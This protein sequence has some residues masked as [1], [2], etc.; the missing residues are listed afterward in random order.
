MIEINHSFSKGMSAI[1]AVLFPSPQFERG[2]RGKTSKEAR[3]GPPGRAHESS[4]DLKSRHTRLA[5][6][7]W[8]LASRLAPMSSSHQ[9]LL[10][11][12][13]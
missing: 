13:G 12:R 5:F 4:T 2:Q 10:P 6:G 9:A 7:V 3:N 1:L 8:H 11:S